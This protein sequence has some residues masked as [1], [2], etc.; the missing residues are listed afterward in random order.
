MRNLNLKNMKYLLLIILLALY[1]PVRAQDTG[2]TWDY[3][4]RPGTEEW[5]AI[6]DYHERL[7]TL[8]IPEEILDE[9]PTTELARICLDYPQMLLVFTRDNLITGLQGISLQFNGFYELAKRKDAGAELVKIYKDLSPEDY[10][11]LG[12]VAKADFIYIELQLGSLSILENMSR[13]E[14]VE[15]LKMS[16]EK[17]NRKIKSWGKLNSWEFN[18]NLWEMAQ[19]YNLDSNIKDSAEY[20]QKYLKEFLFNARIKD[21]DFADE[22]VNEIENYINNETS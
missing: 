6:K 4:I 19:I 2:T 16:Y 22:L 1:M 11:S 9:L 10:S 7:K 5:L 13:D 12:P 15:L 17:F 8:N 18:A 21:V 20:F 14:R 3:P